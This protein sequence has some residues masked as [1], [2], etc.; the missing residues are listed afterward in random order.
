[1]ERQG[2]KHNSAIEKEKENAV[3]EKNEIQVA[4]HSPLHTIN[5]NLRPGSFSKVM[6]E[7]SWSWH[8][9]DIV[10]PGTLTRPLGSWLSW[11]EVVDAT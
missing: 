2:K 11:E 9:S 1:L 10:R 3:E 6:Q 7:V 5:A 8:M 4:G